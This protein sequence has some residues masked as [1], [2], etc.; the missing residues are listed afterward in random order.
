[1]KNLNP[2]HRKILVWTG[3]ALWGIFF[4]ANIYLFNFYDGYL[5]TRQ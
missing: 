4:F 5:Q 3:I 1:M 2:K